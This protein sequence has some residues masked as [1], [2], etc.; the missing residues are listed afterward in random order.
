[1]AASRGE[2]EEAK[3]V[4]A[5]LR[6]LE[7]WNPFQ[8]CVWRGASGCIDDGSW[9][10][11]ET[12][13]PLRRIAGTDLKSST[14]ALHARRVAYLVMKPDAEPVMLDVGIP[15]MGGNVDWIITDGNHRLAAAFYRELPTIEASAS[16]SVSCAKELLGV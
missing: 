5:A 16:G 9:Q 3:V 14:R 10:R 2:P 15:S 1:M 13:V 4:A 12:P 6:R 11:G 8:F 7:P